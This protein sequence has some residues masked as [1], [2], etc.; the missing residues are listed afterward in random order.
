MAKNPIAG[1]SVWAIDSAKIVMV[2]IRAELGGIRLDFIKKFGLSASQFPILHNLRL[3]SHQIKLLTGQRR[4]LLS[5]LRGLSKKTVKLILDLAV[6]VDLHI[7]LE[8]LLRGLDI[9]EHIF[10]AIPLHNVF[11]QGTQSVSAGLETLQLI[12]DQ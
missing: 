5:V 3:S 12:H 7:S 9:L 1:V 10:P 4:E 6:V 2:S 11:G 8:A